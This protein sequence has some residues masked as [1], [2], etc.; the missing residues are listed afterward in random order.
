MGV[1]RLQSQ[2]PAALPSFD[3]LLRHFRKY[4]EFL[5]A[6][7]VDFSL[8]KIHSAAAASIYTISENATARAPIVAGRWIGLAG[9]ILLPG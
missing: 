4:C 2:F 5:R 6:V 9:R 1:V 7:D 3:V 8:G